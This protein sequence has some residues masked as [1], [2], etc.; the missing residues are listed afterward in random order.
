MPEAQELVERDRI[1]AG[2]ILSICLNIE[3]KRQTSSDRKRVLDTV[4][5]RTDY[6]YK[7]NI[8]FGKSYGQ[9]SG[10]IK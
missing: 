10:F 6:S 8:K 4:R 2:E 3:P 5:K 9:T 7:T 1:C